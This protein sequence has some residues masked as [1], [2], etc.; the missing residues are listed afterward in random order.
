M[1]RPTVD[2]PTLVNGRISGP[3]RCESL[4]G[5]EL[6]LPPQEGKLAIVP[7]Q[8]D[9]KWF[10]ISHIQKKS[11][12]FSLYF[13]PFSYHF[14][15]FWHLQE[16]DEKGNWKP[17]TEKGIYIRCPF[18]WR[19]DVPGTVLDGKLEH[20]IFSKGYAGGHLD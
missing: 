11:N 4:D 19:W 9:G 10:G 6:W 7:F 2:Y 13:S 12:S 16:Q 14:G 20:W 1:N 18:S 3:I 15:E 5:T 8:K 17:G